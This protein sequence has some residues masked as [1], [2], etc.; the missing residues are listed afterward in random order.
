MSMDDAGSQ[1]VMWFSQGNQ[2]NWYRATLTVGVEE[3][4]AEQ[5][6]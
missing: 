6:L 2:G 5:Y 4:S 3:V 1:G